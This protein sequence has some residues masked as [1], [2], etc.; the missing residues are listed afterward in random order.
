M[1]GNPFGIAPADRDRGQ[2]LLLHGKWVVGSI[3][4]VS[5]RKT[6]AFLLL[7]RGEYK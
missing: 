1:G 4:L 2:L 5:K 7:R 6:R 3:V